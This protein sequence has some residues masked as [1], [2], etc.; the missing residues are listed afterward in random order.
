M[1]TAC[2]SPTTR[3]RDATVADT[4]PTLYSIAAVDVSSYA[5]LKR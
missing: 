3:P 2:L 5:P 1:L 4:A